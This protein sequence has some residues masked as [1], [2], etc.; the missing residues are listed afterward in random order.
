MM[1]CIESAR[2]DILLVE[3]NPAE[4]RLLCEALSYTGSGSLEVVQA[5]QLSEAFERLGQRRFDIILLDLSLPDAHGLET[6]TRTRAQAPGLPIVVLS[7][8][9][10]DGVALQ[11]VQ[12]GRRI[13]SSRARRMDLSSSAPSGTPS[14]VS[15]SE[16]AL[17][18]AHDELET[19]VRERTAE[20]EQANRTLQGEVA[21]RREAEGQIRNLNERLE[22]R[23]RRIA[24]L[25][26]IEK[27]ISASL[28]LR[29]TLSIILSQVTAQLSVDAAAVLL[30]NHRL[31]VLEY[32]AGM[33]FRTD[34]ITRS[35]LRLGEGWAGRA[36]LERV[37]VSIPDLS[38]PGEPL[39]RARLVA[40][41]GFI[42]YHAVP[43]VAKGQVKGILEIFH[44]AV[45][46]PDAEWREFLATLAGQAAIAIDN[47]SLFEDLQ[48]SNAQLSVA[49]DATIEGWARALDLRDKETEG[50]T[51]RVTDMTDRLARVMGM[52]EDE[53][54]HVR[55]GAL[56]HDIG[57]MG[58]PDDIL[59]KPGPLTEE[60][61][62]VMRRHPGY[63]YE[64]LAP[65]RFLR[66]ALDIPYCHHEKWDG[67]GYPRGL[68]GEQI[69]LAAA[70]LCRG[71]YLGRSPL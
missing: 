57:K 37:N 24:A 34:G 17:R 43:L 31:H 33:G 39:V 41:E 67:T 65:I 63:A 36:A 60:E 58:I 66:L 19:R 2:L 48:R 26:Q 29:L 27:A 15:A 25:R 21:E 32:S 68:R 50:H 52:D 5:E 10:D 18:R 20:L 30:S 51:R 45:L 53:L 6:L 64:W 40:G 70:H 35:R 9:D 44:R 38:E 1:D 13:I 42:A 61:W 11:A 55:R 22:H 28:D 23:L 16:E 69:P 59:L 54:V 7:G 14:S 71:R 47:A 4:A 46:A 12:A 8:L 56:L 3:D 62:S 49:Y